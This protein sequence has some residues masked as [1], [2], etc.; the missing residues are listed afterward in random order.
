MMNQEIFNNAPSV[1][2]LSILTLRRMGNSA[3]LLKAIALY[4]ISSTLD[5]YIPVESNN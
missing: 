2:G 4:F 1:A 5:C 3:R